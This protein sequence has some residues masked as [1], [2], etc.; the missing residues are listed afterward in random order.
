MYYKYDIHLHSD[1]GSPCGNA[2]AKD[3]PRAYKNGGY[4][5]FVLTD[6]FFREHI[7]SAGSYKDGVMRNYNAYLE[8]KKEGDKIGIDV[9][10]GI[11][12]RYRGDDFLTY[13]IDLEFLLANEDI[14]DIDFAEYSR[15]VHEAGGF[16]IQAHPFRNGNRPVVIQ[17]PYIDAI[18]I[19]NASHNDTT[20]HYPAFYNDLAEHF[21]SKMGIIG[22]AGSDTHDIRK[23]DFTPYRKGSMIFGEKVRDEKH[24]IELIRENRFGIYKY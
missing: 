19:F 16:I 15:R 5:G 3:L 23:S 9:F 21:A 1:E 13:G 12:F 8:A 11:E 2:S 4:S 10:F 22:T 7:M 18:E 24:L 14:F 6:H 20:S 17:V